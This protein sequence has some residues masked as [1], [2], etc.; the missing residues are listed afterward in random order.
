MARELVLQVAINA[1][2]G[3]QTLGELQK[4]VKNL[5]AEISSKPIGSKEFND[6]QSKIEE[7]NKAI[8]T[9]NQSFKSIDAGSAS[10]SIGSIKQNIKELNLALN[11]VEIGS[12]IAKKLEA[13][14]SIAKGEL[15]EF[16]QRTEGLSGD[17][18]AGAFA[19]FG[20]GVAGSFGIATNALGI[21][22]AKNEEVSQ[23]REKAEKAIAVVVSA[24]AVAEGIESGVKLVSIAQTRLMIVSTNLETGAQS[25]NIIVKTGA[26]IAQLALNAAM[27]ANPILFVVGALIALGGALAA[28][29]SSADDATL[30]QNAINGAK[31]EGTKRDKVYTDA[32][33]KV[34]EQRQNGY[35]REIAL[36]KAKG[37]T[38]EEI[39]KLNRK[40]YKDEEGLMLALIRTGTVLTTAQ[41]EQLSNLRNQLDILDAEDEKRKKDKS[42]KDKET[43]AKQAEEQKKILSE[44]N[45][46]RANAITDGLNK[47][48]ELERNSLSDKLASIKGNGLAAN[49]LKEEL[50]KQSNQKIQLLITE[51]AKKLS[52]LN[53]KLNIAQAGNDPTEQYIAKATSLQNKIDGLQNQIDAEE[54][55]IAEVNAKRNN[56]VDSKGSTNIPEPDLT[57]VTEAKVELTNTQ[58]ELNKF[59]ND[60]RK[61]QLDNLS[62]ITE[63]AINGGAKEINER[64][65]Q[66]KLLQIAE[67]T[68]YESRKEVLQEEIADQN[69]PVKARQNAQKELDKL[70]SDFVSKQAATNN[71]L[72]ILSTA[73]NDTEAANYILKKERILEQQQFEID[74]AN[75]KGE[76]LLAI[77]A[78]YKLQID[79][80]GKTPEQK[81]EEKQADIDLNVQYGEL[82]FAN[83]TI[84]LERDQQAIRDSTTLTNDKKENLI[85]DNEKK[86][87]EIKRAEE[88]VR[89][90]VTSDAFTAISGFFKQGSQAQK[91]FAI[92]AAT[93]NTYLAASD[94]LAKDPNPYTKIIGMVAIIGA[95]LATVAKIS[96]VQFAKG[97]IVQLEGGGILNHPSLPGT[98]ISDSI[99]ARLSKGESVINARSTQMYKPVLSAINAA[100]G[101][102]AFARGGIVPTLNFAD[103]GITPRTN[104]QG[105]ITQ[106]TNDVNVLG[107]M[108]SEMKEQKQNPAP[109]FVVEN[110]VS[111]VQRQAKIREN[112][113]TF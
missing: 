105:Q 21:F 85:R 28:F 73:L 38:D 62:L 67:K 106:A 69:L 45:V 93:I 90:Q 77:E 8:R 72:T 32:F 68:G 70:N 50:V 110:E 81:A 64:I 80:L 5:R 15:A 103:G 20:A 84:Q 60:F 112:Q 14:L 53:D 74:A 111:E 108:I 109:V 61:T 96:G 51:N 42:K 59:G 41:N 35:N 13:D 48:I 49:T 94:F 1:A 97:G 37:A 22:G 89:L 24:K 55:R 19:K 86:L 18:L 34:I 44:I 7:S 17:K 79:A 76:E 52:E 36:A 99:P 75:A 66:L 98:S 4:N 40:K 78:K 65:S 83:K 107:S 92:G 31:E 6:L 26:R 25:K 102:V 3:I 58:N 23:A 16:K 9:I 101:G 43:G 82:D 54:K 91:T 56:E 100:G 12:P 39:S 11:D 46:I 71:Q 2:G 27:E 113:T 47:E 29:S 104:I 30:K 63:A 57:K 87:T 88:N 10:E 33:N 95:G